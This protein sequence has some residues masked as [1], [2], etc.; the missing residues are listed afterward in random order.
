[1]FRRNSPCGWNNR[2]LMPALVEMLTLLAI[3]V[4]LVACANVAGLLLSRATSRGREIALRLA[5]GAARWQLVRLL[6]LENLLL[7]LGGGIVGIVIGVAG[8]RLF[9]RIPMPTDVPVSLHFALDRRALLFI[10]TV[11]IA[12]TF[13]LACCRRYAVPAP[14]SFRRSKRAM[15]TTRASGHFGDAMYSSPRSWQSHSFCCR[16]G[17]GF[18]GLSQPAPA[19]ARVS[20]G[21]SSSHE[22]RLGVGALRSAQSEQFYRQLLHRARATPGVRSAI[23]S[24]IIPFTF[25]IR[26]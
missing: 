5:V 10:L 6:F 7:A 3:C 2:R 1:M 12:S 23:L 19:R 15:A 13:C 9:A 8:I 18:L 14:I 26:R 20:N 25:D 22:F 21:S 4:L 11:S 24:S 16:I 17:G